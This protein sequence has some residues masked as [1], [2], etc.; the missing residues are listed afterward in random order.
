M[1]FEKITNVPMVLNTSFNE[2]EPIVCAPAEAIECFKKTIDLK[3]DFNLA[4]SNYLFF[5][6][7]S[8]KYDSNFYYKESLGYSKSIKKFDEKLLVPFEYSK[9]TNRIKIGFIYFKLFINEFR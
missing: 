4:Y 2:N 8:D 1:E 7:Y 6:N 9:S 3:P 5:I